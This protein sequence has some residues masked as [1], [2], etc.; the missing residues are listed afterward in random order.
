MALNKKSLKRLSKKNFEEAQSILGN[1][2][3]YLDGCLRKAKK[4][5]EEAS[6]SIKKNKV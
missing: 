2:K 1:L 3:Y 4:N 5:F 6:V